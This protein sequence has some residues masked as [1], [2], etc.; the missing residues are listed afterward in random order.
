MNNPTISVLGGTALS[1]FDGTMISTG[2][3]LAYCDQINKIKYTSNFTAIV[4]L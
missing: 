2:P 4:I 3:V 1:A